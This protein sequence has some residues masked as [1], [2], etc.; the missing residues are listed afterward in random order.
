M[1]F[2]QRQC[3]KGISLPEVLIAIAVLA[4][5]TIAIAGALM[6]SM[7]LNVKDREMT[8]ATNQAQAVLEE[9]RNN[10]SDTKTFETLASIPY[11]FVAGNPKLIYSAQVSTVQTS[12][13]KVSVS[14]YYTDEKQASPTPDLSRPN[15]GKIIQLSCLIIRP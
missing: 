5:T 7:D 15:G 3:K 4:F 1:V 11:T 2:F 12:M 10:A 14:V 6:S 8:Q 9:I 13:K